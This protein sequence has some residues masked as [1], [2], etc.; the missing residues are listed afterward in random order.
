MLPFCYFLNA[1]SMRTLS[2]F[3]TLLVVVVSTLFPVQ[4]ASFPKGA[5]VLYSRTGNPEGTIGV[6]NVD[7]GLDSTIM[8]GAWPVLAAKAPWL[9]YHTGNPT[10]SHAN[11]NHRNTTTGADMRLLSGNDFIVGVDEACG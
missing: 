2:S 3:P 10:F 4:G 8:S 6:V 1:M 11:I 5:S 7:T 9:L